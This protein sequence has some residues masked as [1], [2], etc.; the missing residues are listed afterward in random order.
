MLNHLRHIIL[1]SLLVL[2]ACSEKNLNPDDPQESFSVASQPY[3][4]HDYE[5]AIKK[6]GEFKSRFPYSRFALEAELLI[7][8]CYFNLGKYA[9]AGP[10]YEQFAKLHPKHPQL[11]YVLFRSG[12]SYWMDAPTEIDREQE[13]TGLAIARW[14]RLLKEFPQSQYTAEATQLTKVGKR[15][16]AESEN[17]VTAFYCKKGLWHSCAYHSLLII[18]RYSDHRDLVKEAAKRA[19]MAF[20]RLAEHGPTLE[21]KDTNLFYR[22]M[23]QETLLQKSR[24]LE[25]KAGKI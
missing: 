24:E 23:S 25:E 19:S 20:K 9:E 17:F 12:Q 18:E 10:A 15:R 4:E 11:D 6:L 21:N 3:N 22:S 13:F 2:T 8:N 5:I 16:I 14:E 7:A 1:S